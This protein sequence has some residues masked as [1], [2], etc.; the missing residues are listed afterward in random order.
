MRQL[1]PGRDVQADQRGQ[2]EQT[3]E[4]RV[5]EELHGRVRTAHATE[6]PDEEVHRDEHDLEHHVEQEDVRGGEDAGH[7]GLQHE[8]QRQI[9]ADGAPSRQFLLPRCADDDGH[10]D[11]DERDH[12]QR[13]AIQAQREV[14][15]EARDPVDAELLEERQAAT[16]RRRG[17]VR[18][19]V[20]VAAVE[21]PDDHRDDQL[22][23]REEQSNELHRRLAARARTAQRGH[24]DRAEQ[25][26][27]DHDQQP[28]RIGHANL[29]NSR[30]MTMASV[31]PSIER[32]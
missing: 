10:Q 29:T 18:E 23:Q 6:R 4:Q 7:G 31:P 28:R 32:A 8:D 9:A 20:Q 26:Q 17:R 15:A 21:D 19:V 13:D 14:D 22:D 5:Q 2:H 12:H 27:R 16:R 3:A 30:A 11:R 25:G 24:R 1:L